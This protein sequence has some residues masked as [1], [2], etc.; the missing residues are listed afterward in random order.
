VLDVRTEGLTEASGPDVVTAV[1]AVLGRG[2][3]DG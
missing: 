2:A 1:R 3:L